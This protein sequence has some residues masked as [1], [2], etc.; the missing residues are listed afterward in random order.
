MSKRAV[1]PQSRRHILI[2]DEDWDYLDAAY[3][4]GSQSKYGT[5]AAIRTFLHAKVLQLKARA[6][7]AADTRPRAPGQTEAD[8]PVESE[9]AQ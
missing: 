3:G 9:A 1:L 2:Y 8:T 4:P 5:S 6:S 7:E